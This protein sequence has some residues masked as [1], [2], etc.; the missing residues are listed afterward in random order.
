MYVKIVLLITLF[1]SNLLAKDVKLYFEDKTI[2]NAQTA[3]LVLETKENIKD[4]KLTILK[5]K[6]NIDF[7]KT[8]FKQ[9]KYYALIPTS[10]YIKPDKYKIIISYRLN[11]KKIFDSIYLNVEEGNY[12]SEKITVSDSKVSLSAKNKKRTKREYKNAMELYR[13]VDKKIYWKDDFI[14]PL[15]TKITSE[16][17][18]KRVYNNKLKS[19]HSG[20]DFRAKVGTKIIASNSGIVKMAK[21]RFYAGNSVIIDHGFGVYSCYYH[22]SKMSVKEGDFIKRGEII[23]LS[24]STGRVTGPH[25]HFAFRIN[26]I[27]VDP[28]QAIKTLNKLN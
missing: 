8:P 26:S 3:L 17:G 18:T 21:N 6:T 2:S 27:Q 13:S 11:D 1:F 24:G 22:L 23:G 12:N 10:Y 25:L 20:T 19:Y 7:F 9:N 14:N 16:F 4:A 15:N 28:M 5:N